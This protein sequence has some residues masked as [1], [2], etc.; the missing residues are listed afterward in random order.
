[1]SGRRPGS[2]RSVRPRRNSP[3]QALTFTHTF[4]WTR[5]VSQGHG[6]APLPVG[7]GLGRGYGPSARHESCD[8]IMDQT[9]GDLPAPCSLALH[10]TTEPSPPT[11]LPGERG[12]KP[13]VFAWTQLLLVSSGTYGT[14]SARKQGGS[15]SSVQAPALRLSRSPACG[16]TPG[17]G[18][19]EPV[20][21][22]QRRASVSERLRPPS[23]RLSSAGGRR[24]I[25]AFRNAPPQAFRYP[26]RPF[27]GDPRQS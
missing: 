14:R 8:E 1:M 15:S 19:S 21:W 11:P 26:M 10:G 23:L 17:W 25:P 2:H 6:L 4:G 3:P 18:R 24:T 27:G 22:I 12:A 16:E 13:R 7:E 5:G 20:R 9:I